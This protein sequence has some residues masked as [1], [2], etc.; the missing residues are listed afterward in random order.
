[1][2]EIW[3]LYDTKFRR[4]KLSHETL[5]WS[6]F[7]QVLHIFFFFFLAQT[8]YMNLTLVIKKTN[9]SVNVV[10]NVVDTLTL[11]QL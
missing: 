1:M 7:D 10:Q 11:P 5:L 2:V 9:H 3:Y 8:M 6:K 4:D